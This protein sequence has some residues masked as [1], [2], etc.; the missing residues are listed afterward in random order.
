VTDAKKLV[1]YHAGCADGFCAAWLFH[2]AFPGAEFLPAN[3]GDPPPG[4]TGREVYIVDFS[5]PRVDMLRTLVDAKSVVVLDHHKS[6]EKELGNLPAVGPGSLIRFGMEKSGAVLAWE[7]L[8]ETGSLPD[9][10]SEQRTGWTRD[11]PPVLVRLVQDRDLWLWQMPKSREANAAIRSYP[12]D[13]A[14]WDQLCSR[15]ESPNRFAGLCYEGEAILRN[16]F[17]AI[18]T[19]VKNAREIEID[20]YRVLGVNATTFISEI[21]GELAKG[22]PFGLTWFDKI[23][24]GKCQRI[25]SVRSDKNGID[26]GELAKRH[27]GGGHR[28]A[29]GWTENIGGDYP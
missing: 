10:F 14:V 11:R 26:V 3:Y 20:G 13:Y 21:G 19:H 25:Y 23:T 24:D 16:D 4:V 7:Y 5:Y 18:E 9:R 28:N 1:V 6:A 8:C 2:H 22:R 15:C 29:A 17:Q 27:G 12:M